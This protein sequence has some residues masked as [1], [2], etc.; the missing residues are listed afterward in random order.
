[1]TA[2]ALVPHATD[3]DMPFT[4]IVIAALCEPPLPPPAMV[5]HP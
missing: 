5:G 2:C 4:V 1:M 3:E